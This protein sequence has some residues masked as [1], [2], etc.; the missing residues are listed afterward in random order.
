MDTQFFLKKINDFLS[1]EIVPGVAR[2]RGYEYG[3]VG[4]LHIPAPRDKIRECLKFSAKTK[5]RI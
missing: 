2:L 1:S 4:L 5:C 3:S